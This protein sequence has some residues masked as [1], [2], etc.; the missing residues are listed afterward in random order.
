MDYSL[1]RLC[2][3]GSTDAVEV[4]VLARAYHAAWRALYSSE[5]VG[6]HTIASLGLT[7]DFGG[8]EIRGRRP[9]L[10]EVT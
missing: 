9:I 3:S 1:F 7:I 10:T 4:H 8:A 5:P 6:R 2:E